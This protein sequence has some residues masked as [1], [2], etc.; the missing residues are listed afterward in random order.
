MKQ[1]TRLLFIYLD[2]RETMDRS[3]LIERELNGDVTAGVKVQI[4][5]VGTTTSRV[6][7][8]EKKKKRMTERR[9]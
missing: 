6:T 3:E 4:E 1:S 9:S 5:V 7:R 2:T 8:R